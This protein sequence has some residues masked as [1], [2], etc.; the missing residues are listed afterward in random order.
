[1]LPHGSTRRLPDITAEFRGGTMG[2]WKRAQVCA[3]TRNQDEQRHAQS[4]AVVRAS[5]A[6]TPRYRG[7][8]ARACLMA[9]RCQPQQSSETRRY[10]LALYQCVLQ[11]CGGS[12]RGMSAFVDI[13]GQ[14]IFQQ[15]S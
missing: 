4:R 9:E 10:K 1:M 3:N 11:P 5:P 6:R 13:Q 14:L 12:N 15:G 8:L 7:P 2:R